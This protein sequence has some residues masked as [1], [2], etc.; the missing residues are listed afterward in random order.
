MAT[1]LGSKRKNSQSTKCHCLSYLNGA[2]AGLRTRYAICTDPQIGRDIQ[3]WRRRIYWVLH[4]MNTTASPARPLRIMKMYPNN[5]WSRIWLNMH[6]A[7]IPDTVL[8]TWYMV[9]HDILPTKERLKTIAIT[10]S[11]HCNHCGQT[12]TMY[13]R[14]MECEAGRDMWEMDSSPNG[15]DT[16][17]ELLLCFG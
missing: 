2:R 10:D 17:H 11:D 3:T 9:I 1:Q 13:H 15:I 12:D 14:V 16:P 4:T 7:L 8:S 5:N 6:T